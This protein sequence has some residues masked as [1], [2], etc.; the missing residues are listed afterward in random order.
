MQTCPSIATFRS[1]LHLMQIR[2]DTQLGL[3]YMQ[4]CTSNARPEATHACKAHLLCFAKQPIINTGQS[5][6]KLAHQI[7]L[8]LHQGMQARASKHS[9]HNVQ[10]C[11]LR[12]REVIHHRYC[13]RQAHCIG[14][15]CTA[16]AAP[17]PQDMHTSSQAEQAVALIGLLHVQELYEPLN[18]QQGWNLL[19]RHCS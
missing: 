5:C 19:D 13:G 11:W 8:P 2:T 9:R 16:G 6:C 12:S 15:E 18:M 4:L 10:Q 1:D 3:R 17:Q 14:R 7:E